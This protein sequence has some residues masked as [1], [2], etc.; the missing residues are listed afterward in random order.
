MCKHG[1]EKL[2]FKSV[3]VWQKSYYDKF[4]QQLQNEVY[5]CNFKHLDRAWGP[6]IGSNLIVGLP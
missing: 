5:I 1:I 3:Y 2:I 4:M 6:R